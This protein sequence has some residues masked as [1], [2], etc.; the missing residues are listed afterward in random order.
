MSNGQQAKANSARPMRPGGVLVNFPAAQEHPPESPAPRVS[1]LPAGSDPSLFE[2]CQEL[3]LY[4]SEE[5]QWDKQSFSLPSRTTGREP[6]PVTV[7]R[8]YVSDDEWSEHPGLL[9]PTTAPGDAQPESLQADESLVQ[10]VAPG[11]LK[12]SWLERWLFPD[13]SAQDKRSGAR[14]PAPGLVAHFWTG[15]PPK[16]QPDRKS[17]V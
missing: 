6:E 5:R 14:K 17:V 13:T 4:C 11:H 8:L 15:G 10:P 9:Q 12:R 3:P 1:D 2:A 7:Q 16:S